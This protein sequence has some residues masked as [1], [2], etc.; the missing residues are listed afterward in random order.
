M[1][2][3]TAFLEVVSLAV[4]GIGAVLSFFLRGQST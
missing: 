2:A 4:T 3:M 1:E